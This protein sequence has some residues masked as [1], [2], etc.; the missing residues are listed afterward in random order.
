MTVVYPYTWR[1]PTGCFPPRDVLDKLDAPLHVKQ[2]RVVVF[3]TS[4]K[5]AHDILARLGMAPRTHRHLGPAHGTDV[6]IL[7]AGGLNK[8]GYVF[9]IRGH[10]TV[11]CQPGTE[12]GTR[13]VFRVED[14]PD[15]G[16]VVT[17]AM[18]KAAHEACM[19]A[20]A[21]GSTAMGEDWIRIALTAALRVQ[22][23]DNDG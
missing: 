8:A 20:A 1:E 18:V 14:L 9:I 10:K 23:G 13:Y 21:E 3:A 2:A 6:R 15:D 12:W 16:P 17:D 5:T 22:E 4:Q 11:V 7:I 19:A